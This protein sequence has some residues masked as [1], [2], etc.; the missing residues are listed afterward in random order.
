MSD[1]LQTLFDVTPMNEVDL[2]HTATIEERAL[3]FHL[4]NPRVYGELRRLAFI[5]VNRGHKRFGC[6]MLAEQLRWSWYERTIDVS[7]YKLSNT[8]V[9]FYARLLMKNEPELVGVFETRSSPHS[10]PDV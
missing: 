6:K 3:A 7:G 5:L 9:A 4:A 8:Y 10:S 2:P 1:I